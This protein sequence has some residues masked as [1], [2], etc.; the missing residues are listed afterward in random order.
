KVWIYNPGQRRVRLAP[1][2]SY[3]TPNATYGGADFGDEGDT[4]YGKLDRYNWKIIGKQEMYIPAN[5]YDF[6]FHN[7]VAELALPGHFKPDS[8]RWELRRVWVM[9][10]TV[11]PGKR[12]VVAR[13][14]FYADED[15]WNQVM[16]SGWDASGKYYRTMISPQTPDYF[17]PNAYTPA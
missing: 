12:H 17:R 13:K 16:W 1:E 5:D 6:Q 10:A 7:T 4:F 11:A 2:I 8:F 14:R 15:T 3:D 9:E